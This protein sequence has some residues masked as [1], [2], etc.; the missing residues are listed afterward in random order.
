MVLQ[1]V[2]TGDT[3][4]ASIVNYTTVNQSA[5][6]GRDYVLSSGTIMFDRGDNSS[7]VVVLLLANHERDE[8]SVFKVEVFKSASSNFDPTDIGSVRSI[9]VEIENL[10]LAGPYFTALPQ[11]D[12]VQAGGGAGMYYDLPLACITVRESI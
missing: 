2:R 9:A 12:N 7:E 4:I 5:L 11:L 10:H 6:S 1:L 8:N 3:S